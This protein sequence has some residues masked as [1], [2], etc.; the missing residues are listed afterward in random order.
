MKIL[1]IAPQPFFQPRGTPISV[2]HRLNTLSK[3]GH[4]IDLVTYHI[5]QTIPF[6]NV[7]YHRMMRIPFVKKIKIG[8]SKTKLLLDFFLFF[9]ALS[10]LVRH[11]YDVLH[12]HEEAGFF[13]T[14]LAKLFRLKHLYDMHSSLPQQLTNFKFSKFR[15]LIG[16]FEGLEDWTIN[17]A[18]AVIT[19]CPELF[20]YVKEN[21]PEKKQWLIENVADNSTVFGE[22]AQNNVD[23]RQANALNGKTIIL[24]SGTFEPYQGI[25]LLINASEKV[26]PKFSGVKFVLVGGHDN[27]IAHYRDMIKSKQL[28]EY[29]YFAGQVKPDEVPGYLEA[30]DIL[31]TP[32]IEGNNTPLKIYEYL[33]SGKPIVAT[34]HITHTQVL[35]DD[36]AVLTDIDSA[37]FA[38]GLMNILKDD[39]QRKKIAG[40]A[41]R[42]ADEKYSYEVYVEK[43]RSIYDYL[44]KTP[45]E[46]K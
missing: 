33:R 6:E 34:R 19:I 25:D 3:L 39:S 21:Y 2:L 27:Q 46:V 42:L 12:T 1:M 40:N 20:N 37:S 28:D 35:S 30:A 13:G 31:V 41:R 4:N 45:R 14:G 9:K 17:N 18:N 43:T 32:R 11:R 44:E 15:P 23:I 5:G 7:N 8:P 10:M 16:M 38:N 36:V 22:M 29:F 26:I 24:Y